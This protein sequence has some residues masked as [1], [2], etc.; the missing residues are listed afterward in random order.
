M[1]TPD[2]KYAISP[3]PNL[4]K[5]A[6]TFMGNINNSIGSEDINHHTHYLEFKLERNYVSEYW[7]GSSLI[8]RLGSLG[9]ICCSE[10]A[11]PK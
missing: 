2:D 3:H 8:K 11:N 5:K 6:T 1:R 4:R 9:F 7:K 10:A